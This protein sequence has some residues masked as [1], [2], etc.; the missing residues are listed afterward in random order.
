[1]PNIPEAMYA[2]AKAFIKNEADTQMLG[3][4][5]E[6]LKE[7]GT[8]KPDFDGSTELLDYV[9]DA[10]FGENPLPWYAYVAN[11]DE[12]NYLREWCRLNMGGEDAVMWRT[13]DADG[14]WLVEVNPDFEDV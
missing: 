12:L 4:F 7:V 13:W 14:S 1:M 10:M 6:R 5:E 9:V 8:R 11:D 3:A 2:H